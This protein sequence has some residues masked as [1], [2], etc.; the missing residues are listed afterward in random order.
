MSTW[1][2]L[3]LSNVKDLIEFLELK[4]GKDSVKRLN[5]AKE[6]EVFIYESENEVS[7]I[8]SSVY[9]GMFADEKEQ[10]DPVNLNAEFSKFIRTKRHKDETKKNTDRS[11][12]QF[13]EDFINEPEEERYVYD[14]VDVD[15]SI[16]SV[17]RNIRYVESYGH[18]FVQYVPGNLFRKGMLIVRIKKAKK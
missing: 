3:S 12:E 6:S 16:G 15:K 13:V 2:W 17:L 10:P 8:P 7:I 1:G 5:I 14:T 4:Y 11:V 9:R 18:E